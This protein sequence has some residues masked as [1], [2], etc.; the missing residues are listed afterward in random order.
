MADSDLNEL[1]NRAMHISGFF[2]KEVDIERA[3]VDIR[4]KMI[5]FSSSISEQTINHAIDI[6]IKCGKEE[7]FGRTTVGEITG[8][9]P[10]LHPI[11][12]PILLLFL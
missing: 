10:K 5:S 4:N 3:K 6:F 1:H 12:C 9:L 2:D 11:L 7:C 8:L